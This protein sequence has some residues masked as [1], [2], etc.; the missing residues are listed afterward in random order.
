MDF[1]GAVLDVDGTVVRG[2]DPIPGAPAGY[3]RLREAGVE[4]L[5]VSNNPTKTPRAYVDRLGGAGYDID[6][7]RVFTA[8]SVTTRYLREHH[9]D[10]DL[11]CIAD[12]GLL[13]QFAEAG[14]STTDDVDAADALVASIDREFDYE[15]LC[16]ALWALER[17]IPFIGT[18]PDVVIPAPERDVPGSG[19]VINAIAG[20][21]ERDPDAVL[22]KP[23]DTAIEM[24]RE[25]LPHPA[26]ECLV[27]GDRLDTDIALG[28]RAGMTTVLVR[29]GVTDD[30]DLAASEIE[31][32]HVLD[33]LGQIDRVV[34]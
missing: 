22:G 10:D 13:D 16:T 23:S 2:D 12:P 9:R 17:D 24:V 28:E 19:A 32:D 5:F 8:G 11:L 29:S 1:S 27:V 15:D 4:T 31:P 14:L 21:A 6:A 34:G 33:H 20:V 3:R 25:R 7:D 30:A 18:D 26:K